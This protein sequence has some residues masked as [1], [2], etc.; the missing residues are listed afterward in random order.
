MGGGGG[1]SAFFLHKQIVNHFLS[2]D[3]LSGSR[4]LA[5]KIYC[6]ATEF[7]VAPCCFFLVSFHFVCDK[8]AGLACMSICV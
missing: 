3:L 1:G 6:G 8:K 2:S 7:R 4:S 5:D